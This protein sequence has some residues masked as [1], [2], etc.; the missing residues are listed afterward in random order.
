LEAPVRDAVIGLAAT[1]SGRVRAWG[2]GI[3]AGMVVVL[4]GP[5]GASASAPPASV[6]IRSSDE[7][8]ERELAERYAPVVM[9]QEQPRP[10]SSEGEPFA[11]MAVDSLLGNPEIALR[12]VGRGDPVVEW[13]P[14][15]EALFGLGRGFYLDFPGESL[16]PGCVYERDFLRYTAGERPTVYAHTVQQ[17][18][19]PDK[20]VLQY[21]FFWYYNE[22]ANTHEGDWE[23]V[24]IVFPASSAREALAVEPTS[25]G[26]AQ[27]EGGERAAWTDDKLEREGDR[28]V[29]HASAGSHASYFNAALYLGRNGDE[30]FGCD[31]TG[32]D[33]V[34]LDPAVVLLPSGV[35]AADDP[36]AWLAFEGRWGERGRGPFNGPTG[37][38]DK[39]RWNRPINWQ[40]GLR[41]SS[42]VIP[43]GDGA[44]ASL[45]H[46]F[47]RGVEIGSA[48]LIAFKLSPPRAVITIAL[49]AAVGWA[50]IRRTTWSRV[51]A[52]PVVRRRS[53]G[54]ILRNSVRVPA[55]APLV[56]AGIAL[57]AVPL[58]ILAGAVAAVVRA[59]PFVGR[60]VTLSDAGDGTRLV[61]SLM[62]GGLASL[63][64]SV[65][66]AALVA[67]TLGE[68]S[69]GRSPTLGA[70][71]VAVASRWRPLLGALVRCVAVVGLAFL[72]VVGIPFAL[73]R[74]VSYQ[75]V[76]QCVV[77]EDLDGRDAPRRSVALVRHRW[78][79]TAVVLGLIGL[80][81][82]VVVGA[83]A[84]LLLVVVRPPFW[85]LSWLIGLAEL[86]VVPVAAIA[87]TLLYG[88]AAS[89]RR[90]ADG[91]DAEIDLAEVVRT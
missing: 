36:L 19:H 34:R 66:I 41:D 57:L 40:E 70:A 6:V 27:H 33:A 28:I 83:A 16:D 20:Y 79:H 11:P 24:Q 84:M 29:V 71:L 3:A 69:A 85:L 64:A 2:V 50:L 17:A 21:W 22:W 89:A 39:G 5:V 43:A 77:L 25:V 48:Q 42:V 44:A 18:G 63:L 61:I 78:W 73:H 74:L 35:D 55:R 9:V 80:A 88:D 47:C 72:T 58:S 32:G 26:Y 68:L 59:L 14:T 49:L 67:W 7:A 10:C 1:A 12:Q 52:L 53:A 81:I 60:V 13:A 15:R 87:A 37:P 45:A 54:Q 23:G 62:V 30:G 65:V 4:A 90:E 91:A 46:A 82:T 38:A 51:P 86:A 56:F 31:D 75:F 76:A 8:A